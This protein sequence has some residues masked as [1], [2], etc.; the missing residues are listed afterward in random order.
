MVNSF[1]IVFFIMV[2]FIFID[3]SLPNDRRS[4]LKRQCSQYLSMAEVLKMEIGVDTQSEPSIDDEE[5]EHILDGNFVTSIDI[6]DKV[7]LK[8][9]VAYNILS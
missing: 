3:K 2:S 1:R 5:L 6:S 4:R 8:I 9:D 7:K